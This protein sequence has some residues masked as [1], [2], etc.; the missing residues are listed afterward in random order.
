MDCRLPET[1]PLTVRRVA[2]VDPEVPDAK[3]LVEDLWLYN[4]VGLLGG[5]AKVCKTYLAAELSLAVASGL[6]AL[7]RFE[8]RHPGPVLFFGAEDS[9]QALRSRFEGLAT[10]RGCNIDNLPVHLI[11]VPLLRLDRHHDLQR[12]C[13]AIQA[14][15]PRLL[16]LDPY[17]RMVDNIDENSASAVSTVLGSLRAIQRDHQLAI[18][19]VHHARKAH[20]SN[21]YQAYRGSSDFAAW[22]DC[23]LLMTRKNK[24]LTLAVQHRSARSPDPL[25]LKLEQNPA[26]HLLC[27]DGQTET[28]LCADLNPVADQIRYQLETAARPMTTVELREKLRRRK[29]DIVAAI[30]WLRQRAIL[31]R[32]S[33][34][35]LLCSPGPTANN[36]TQT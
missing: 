7:G 17:V 36:D 29:S 25:T 12:L 16:V 11:D 14:C 8:T 2:D 24:L 35:W 18:M 1:E 3:W 34:G 21:P 32:T 22:A 20:A 9:P 19:L 6:P 28:T 33:N 13:A 5:Q 10:A 30:E 4:G 26:P 23:N 27:S 31:R 15:K